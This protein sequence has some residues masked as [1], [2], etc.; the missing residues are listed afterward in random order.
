MAL[1]VVGI[2]G[3]GVKAADIVLTQAYSLNY[4]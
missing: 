1:D 3:I 4:K 2:Q